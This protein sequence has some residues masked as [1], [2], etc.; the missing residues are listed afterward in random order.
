MWGPSLRSLLCCPSTTEERDEEE[1][2]KRTWMGGGQRWCQ[3]VNG[4]WK[5]GVLAEGLEMG[6][7][8]PSG[9]AGP[10]LEDRRL[11]A[12]LYPVP[13]LFLPWCGIAFWGVDCA[14][15]RRFLIPVLTPYVVKDSRNAEWECNFQM[16]VREEAEGA[17]FRPFFIWGKIS[18]LSWNPE[19]CFITNL[20]KK[21]WTGIQSRT[22]WKESSW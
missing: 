13:V 22:F 9:F 14:R 4:K 15:Q 6:R 18:Y 10:Q 12:V 20:P 16:G 3:R 17:K 11:P 1:S 5:D 7:G 2:E 19:P 21:H 8:N